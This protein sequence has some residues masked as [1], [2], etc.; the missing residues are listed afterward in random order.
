MSINVDQFLLCVDRMGKGKVKLL[1]LCLFFVLKFPS[2]GP[3][4][5]CI[6]VSEK[7]N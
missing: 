7:F 5:K 2:P 4:N 1:A 6:E 3:M